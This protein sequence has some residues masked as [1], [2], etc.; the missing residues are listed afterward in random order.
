M[1]NRLIITKTMID[2]NNTFAT[3]N[4]NGSNPEVDKVVIWIESGAIA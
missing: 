3:K 4:I 2:I 1:E